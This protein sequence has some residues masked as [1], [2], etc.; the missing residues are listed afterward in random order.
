MESGKKAELII[1]TALDINW[2]KELKERK[3]TRKTLKSKR[4]S[5]YK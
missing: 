3:I 2:M 1:Y 4:R 5:V